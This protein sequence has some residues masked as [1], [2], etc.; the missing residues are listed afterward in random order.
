M[1]ES[2]AAAAAPRED[3]NQSGK[4]GHTYCEEAG[5]LLPACTTKALIKMHVSCTACT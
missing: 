4:L 1:P 2:A 3:R 5:R